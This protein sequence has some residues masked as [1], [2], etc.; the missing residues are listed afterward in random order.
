MRVARQGIGGDSRRDPRYGWVLV[1]ALGTTQIVSWGVLYYAFA[2]FLTPMQGELGLSTAEIT[3]AFSLA[4]GVS[5]LAGLA[6]G[7]WLDRHSPRAPI[8]AGSLLAA[9]LVLAW[10][11]VDSLA[12]LY[13]VFAGIG[14]AMAAVLY[15][16]AFIVITKWFSIRRRAALTALTLIAA[17]ASLIFSPLSEYLVAALGGATRWWS[18]PSP[19]RPSPC[20]F[21]R[22][23][24]DPLP[25][26][27][28]GPTADIGGSTR[29]TAPDGGG[30]SRASGC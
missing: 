22:S 26:T 27:S 6:V 24:C 8:T 21:T 3:G 12:G 29:S 25:P 4:L 28:P 18:S 7:R 1:G 16:P 10:S 9:L 5:A 23:S 30:P 19:S 2:V 20:P 14:I 13:L 15:E 11:R 17:L